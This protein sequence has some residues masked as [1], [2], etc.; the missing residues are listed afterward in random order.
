MPKPFDFSVPERGEGVGSLRDDER[1]ARDRLDVVDDGGAGVQPGDRGEGRLQPRLAAMPLQ[2]VEQ[3]GFL[4]AL[5]GAGPGV[6]DDVEV[7]PRT[8]DVRAQVAGL[9]GLGDRLVQAPDDVQHLA[10]HV[11][12]RLVRPDRVRR[13]DRALDQGVRGRQHDRDVLA[14]ARL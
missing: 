13:D 3:R 6:H 14:G 11:D 2:R 7:E 1:H 4:A 9:V 10:A 8:Q 5:V 12:E